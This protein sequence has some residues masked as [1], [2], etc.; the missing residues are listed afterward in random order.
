MDGWV[1]GET[2]GGR[3]VG[4]RVGGREGN[5]GG[6]ERGKEGKKGL[7][8]WS[9]GDPGPRIVAFS[10]LRALRRQR[11]SLVT[12]T[13]QINLYQLRHQQHQQQ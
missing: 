12:K 1:D 5:E 4:S 6:M 9:G 2:T 7:K 3:E 13:P 10:L 8:G 11:T